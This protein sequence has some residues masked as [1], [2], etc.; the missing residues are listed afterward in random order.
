MDSE[1]LRTD[2]RT[3]ARSVEESARPSGRPGVQ[4]DRQ[5]TGRMDGQTDGRTTERIRQHQKHE[6]RIEWRPLPC[7]GVHC[8][9][10]PPRRAACLPGRARQRASEQAAVRLTGRFNGLIDHLDKD[11]NP[12]VRTLLSVRLSRAI[13]SLQRLLRRRLQRRRAVDVV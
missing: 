13:A 9:S 1:L 3:L 12:D 5:S 11:G 10:P 4:S 7:A 2:G 6:H 8:R